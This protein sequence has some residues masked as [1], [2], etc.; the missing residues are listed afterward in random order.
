MHLTQQTLTDKVRLATIL[1][2]SITLTNFKYLR[3][4]WKKNTEE[5]RL[6]RVTDVSWTT[7]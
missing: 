1:G 5:E 6:L 4:V 7:P 3:N 2:S